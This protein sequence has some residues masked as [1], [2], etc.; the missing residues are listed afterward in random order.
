MRVPVVNFDALVEAPVKYGWSCAQTWR[1]GNALVT[2]FETLFLG[3]T[4]WIRA[5]GGS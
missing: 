2:R 3:E 4:C 1:G 5:A